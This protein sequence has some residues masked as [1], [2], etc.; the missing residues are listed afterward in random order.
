MAEFW[1]LGSIATRM[2][3]TKNTLL[4]WHEHRS[5]LMY[6]R[7]RG[8]RTVWYSNDGLIS[9]WEVARCRIAHADK[10]QHGRTL[11]ARLRPST[12][13]VVSAAEVS[14]RGRRNG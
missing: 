3:I 10:Y 1:G 4:K 12:V 8:P 11:R 9:A 14:R 13:P 2:G 5:F 6:P 7:R